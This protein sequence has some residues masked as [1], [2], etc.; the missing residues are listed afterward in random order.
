MEGE[1]RAAHLNPW[2]AF[3]PC[4][5]EWLTMSTGKPCCLVQEPCQVGEVRFKVSAWGEILMV[6]HCCQHATSFGPLILKLWYG[7]GIG[8]KKINHTVI[9][10]AALLHTRLLSQTAHHI[11][12][13]HSGDLLPA[14]ASR[15]LTGKN[16]NRQE[17]SIILWS[18][19]DSLRLS[20]LEIAVALSAIVFYSDTV[21]LCTSWFSLERPKMPLCRQNWGST[22]VASSYTNIKG[23]WLLPNILI[24]S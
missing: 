23:I 20:L 2:P 4:S 24:T 22:Q 13:W 3:P 6:W 12:Q 10:R 11:L 18:K 7:A 17:F 5:T 16:G 8:G 14:S 19:S 21:T 1:T 9:K 15:R